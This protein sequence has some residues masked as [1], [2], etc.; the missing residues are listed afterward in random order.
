MCPI[1]VRPLISALPPRAPP[2]ITPPPPAASETMSAIAAR[3]N[4]PS[5]GL[6]EPA[7]RSA[8]HRHP[9]LPLTALL[10]TLNGTPQ[11]PRSVVRALSPYPAFARPLFSCSLP[12]SS[13]IFA[14]RY[15][16]RCYSLS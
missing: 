5:R 4:Q 12:S 2:P 9:D 13:F 10:M 16:V 1:S 3:G 7:G 14:L 15:S 11:C 6:S 8:L